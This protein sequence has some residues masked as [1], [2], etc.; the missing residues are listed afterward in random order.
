LIKNQHI[1]DIRAAIDEFESLYVFTFDELRSTHMADVRRRFI[2][3][4]LFL[5]K[6]KLA[7]VALGKTEPEAHADQTELV[8]AELA[9]QCGLLFT[10][11]DEEQVV[12][13]FEEYEVADFARAGTVAQTTITLEPG[14][15]PMFQ[16]TMEPMLRTK[17]G[18][19]VN[20]ERGVIH[21]LSPFTL[22]S[23]GEELAPEQSQL[24][25]LLKHKTA[26]FKPRLHCKWW[27]GQFKKF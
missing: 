3:G 10:N 13:W 23:E 7:Q 22:C 11:E 21:L 1:A 24:L 2:T 17:L 12:R 26:T 9:G 18:M 25:A 20:L 6:N 16:H 19:P 27:D 8:S 4:R 15:M 5:G 14:P